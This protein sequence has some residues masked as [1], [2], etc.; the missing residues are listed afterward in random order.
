MQRGDSVSILLG[1]KM[2]LVIRNVGDYYIIVGPCYI[3]SIINREALQAQRE[4]IPITVD[5]V[6]G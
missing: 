3:Y 5:L 4:E 2:L 6:F 1:C